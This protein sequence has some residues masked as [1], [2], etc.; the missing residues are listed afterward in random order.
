MNYTNEN[1]KAQ[2]IF[3][4]YNQISTKYV[5]T[6]DHNLLTSP[7]TH[8][9]FLSLNKSSIS[10]CAPFQTPTVSQRDSIY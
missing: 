5:H 8:R 7:P 6:R 9:L 4:N 2:S 1:S 10:E 3:L